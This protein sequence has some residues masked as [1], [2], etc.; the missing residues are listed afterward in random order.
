MPTP[1]PGSTAKREA[2]AALSHP[3]ILSIYDFGRDEG[4][5]FAVMELLDGETLRE[6]LATGAL[7]TRKALEYAAQI[8]RGLAAA[9]RRGSCTGT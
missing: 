1:C 4:L 5:A 8:A 6:R 2:V 3:N 7:P 9:T